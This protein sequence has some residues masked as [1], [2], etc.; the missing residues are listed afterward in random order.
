MHPVS[1]ANQ[2]RVISLV[3]QILVK[4]LRIFKI[5]ETSGYN[6]KLFRPFICFLNLCFLRLL[7]FGFCRFL[8]SCFLFFLLFLSFLC[9]LFLSRFCLFC[10]LFCLRFFT[11]KNLFNSVKIKHSPN[12]QSC[13]RNTY[14]YRQNQPLVSASFFSSGSSFCSGWF[15]R[16]RSLCP[17]PGRGLRNWLFPGRLFLL[18][19]FFLCFL[20]FVSRG[21]CRFLLFFRS[22][23][24]LLFPCCFFVYSGRFFCLGRFF[25]GGRSSFRLFLFL[26]LI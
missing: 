23:C 1:F 26:S 3:D 20:C 2:F 24:L 14:Y 10:Y 15:F 17:F 19:W 8:L 9:F 5:S 4:F 12:K 21:F 6:I 13:H 18:F 22:G 7:F 25:C 11:G 16:R